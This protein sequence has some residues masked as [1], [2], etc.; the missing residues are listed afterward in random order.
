MWV[1]VA[2][3]E[4]SRRAVDFG[5]VRVDLG[6]RPIFEDVD[7]PKAA[8]W[9]SGGDAADVERAGAFAVSFGQGAR[10][11]TFPDGADPISAAKAEVMR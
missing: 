4:R 5:S 2:W 11:F 1:V 9:I 8:V 6:E 10:V 3:V 7:V